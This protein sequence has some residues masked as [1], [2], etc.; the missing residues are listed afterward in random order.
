MHPAT[1]EPPAS[2]RL[3]EPAE[4][5]ETIMA[6]RQQNAPVGS[7]PTP[8]LPPCRGRTPRE[9]L[10]DTLGVNWEV[11]HGWDPEIIADRL[12]LRLCLLRDRIAFP[13]ARAARRFVRGKLWFSFGYARIEDH[14]RERFGRSG[15][16][17]R[18]LAALAEAAER[19]PGLSEAMT[20]ED[21]GHPIGRVVALL[22]GR[23]AAAE[24]CLEWVGHARSMTVRELREEMHKA[25]LAGS[26]AP[27]DA[28]QAGSQ[29]P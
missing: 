25:R 10:R 23:T 1:Q 3:S 17:V 15:R 5:V 29:S 9:Q 19:L 6:P 20:G 14:A 2:Q 13:L 22:I 16:W 4:S 28:R 7:P 21:G 27:L 24:T 12:A 11:R 26:S 8:S 18:D